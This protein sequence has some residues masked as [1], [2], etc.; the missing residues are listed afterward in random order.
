VEPIPI[1]LEGSKALVPAVYGTRL[2]TVLLIRRNGEAHF[3]ERDVW[4]RDND[5][6]VVKTDPPTQREFQF[7][8]DLEAIGRA[9]AAPEE[10]SS[11]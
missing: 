9:Q 4:K 11:S 2:S 5:G 3:I 7:T 1:L 6:R 10:G 8:L